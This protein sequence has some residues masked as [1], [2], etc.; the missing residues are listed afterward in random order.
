MISVRKTTCSLLL[1]FLAAAAFA[2]VS[3]APVEALTAEDIQRYVDAAKALNLSDDNLKLDDEEMAKDARFMGLLRGKLRVARLIGTSYDNEEGGYILRTQA[4]PLIAFLAQGGFPSPE[5][6]IENAVERIVKPL[7]LQTVVRELP[8]Y[9]EAVVTTEG[10]QKKFQKMLSRDYLSLDG[11]AIFHLAGFPEIGDKPYYTA[12]MDI[13]L[14]DGSLSLYEG[15]SSVEGWL[16]SFW[17]RR[18]QDGTM[19]AAKMAIDWLNK[20]LGQ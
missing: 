5:K 9:Y 11:G 6:L 12:A 15:D 1:P 16:Y 10:W 8:R 3:A 18:W 4:G 7:E 14:K 20:A 13:E 2:L 17:L 19:D